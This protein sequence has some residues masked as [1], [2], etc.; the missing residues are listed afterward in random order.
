M[1]ITSMDIPV[2]KKAQTLM[3]SPENIDGTPGGGSHG[4]PMGKINPNIIVEPG[5]TITLLDS[6]G[7]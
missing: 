5:E 3:F 7:P 6:D 1:E 4:T 2:V